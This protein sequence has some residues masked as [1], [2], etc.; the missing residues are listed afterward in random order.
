MNFKFQTY[1]E[2]KEIDGVKCEPVEYLIIDVPE[3]Y[4]GEVMEKVGNAKSELINMA[5]SRNICD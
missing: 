1:C 3:D 2:H 4:M 5:S